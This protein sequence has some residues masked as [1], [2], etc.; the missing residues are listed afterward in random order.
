MTV[1]EAKKTVLALANSEIGYHEKPAIHNL[2]KSMQMLE[3]ATGLN[4]HGI[5]MQL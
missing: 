3:A 4:T 2:M 1:E 5:W